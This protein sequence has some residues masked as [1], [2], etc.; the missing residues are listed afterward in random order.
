MTAMSTILDTLFAHAA[1]AGD[2]LALRAPD[3]E[4][5]WRDLPAAIERESARLLQAGVG[6]GSVVALASGAIG[7]AVLTALGV[8]HAGGVPLVLGPNMAAPAFTH[9]TLGPGDTVTATAGDAGTTLPEGTAWLRATGGTTSGQPRVVAF[10]ETRSL[11]GARR[12]GRFLGLAP[13]ALTVTTLPPA[14][15]YGWNAWLGPLVAGAGVVFTPAVAPRGLLAALSAPGVVWGATTPPVV[16]ALA[17]LP[18]LGGGGGRPAPVICGAAAH[19]IAEAAELERRHGVAVIERY[20]ATEI[21]PIAQADEPGGPLRR[22]EDLELR[23]AGDPPSVEVASPSVALGYVG[24]PL[25]HGVFRTAD[26]ATFDADGR[27]RL[28]GRIDRVV[29]RMSRPVD[30]TAVER[31]V[32][33]LPGVAR[34]RVRVE[35]TALDIA[36]VAQVVARPGATL[37]P[38]ALIAALATRLTPW[39]LPTAIELCADDAAASAEKWQ[40]HDEG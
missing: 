33:A 32:A 30:L 37:E 15:A 28:A 40:S 24:G 1:G 16:R 14:T 6:R 17:R 11:L 21:G 12:Y 26:A 20:G 18:A 5:R 22:A 25:F 2:R 3:G 29:R 34:A 13:G 4:V 31:A 23:M 10:D 7:R 38:H 27:F 35:R 9:F 8:R 39:E 36:L 19:P